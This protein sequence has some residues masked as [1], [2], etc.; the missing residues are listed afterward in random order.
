MKSKR[1]PDRVHVV[2]TPEQD[3]ANPQAS[4]NIE[5][6]RMLAQISDKLKR[7]EAERYELLNELREY[8]KSLR[9]LEDKSENSEKAYLA[10]ENTVK[11]KGNIDTESLQRQARFEKS[12]KETEDKIVKAIAGQ[13]LIDKRIS[14]AESKQV[15]IDQR[16]D[17]SVAEQARLDRQL[18]LTAQDKARL[19]RKVERL[20]D[21]VTETQDTLRSKAM[22][23]L[24]DQS[25]AAGT[26]SAPAWGENSPQP[27][28]V[29]D[30]QEQSLWARATSVQTLSISALIIAA[31]LGGYA[32][33]QIQKPDFPEITINDNGDLASLGNPPANNLSDVNALEAQKIE[34]RLNI[35][36]ENTVNATEASAGTET[37]P[38]D[39]L[40]YSDDQLIE[41][42]NQDPEG[43]AAQLNDIEPSAANAQTD[44]AQEGPLSNPQI[45]EPMAN[46]DAVAFKQDPSI[47]KA[48]AESK[49][50]GTLESRMQP[51]GNLPPSVRRI[52][53][54]AFKGN[55]EA[56]H[57][58]AAIYTA[59]QGG[60][61]QNFEKAAFWFREASDN[62]IANARY[63]LGVLNHQGLGTER[64]LD[65]A[66]YWYRE[67]AKLGHAE[68][69]YNLGIAHI[70]GIGTDY[71]PKL[72]A[73]FF[74]RA[75]NNG[76][77]EAAYNLGLIYE[78]GLLGTAKPDEAI[79]WYKIAADQGSSDAQSALEQ[80][81]QSLQIG[82]SDIDNLVERM[83]Q[84]NQS[85][86]GRRAGPNGEA[87]STSSV[88]SNQAMI[89]QIQEYLMLTG[90]YTGPADGIN[91]PKTEEAIKAYQAANNLAVTGKPSG[92]LLNSMIGSAQ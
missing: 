77:M 50:S 48:I 71:D 55:A 87:A 72:A 26:L 36:E 52:E 20:E 18:E 65:K 6:V 84:I 81:A 66:L 83:Q 82:M 25:A 12:L 9:E 39:V 89:A 7:S 91:G 47:A 31:L 16:L 38:E 62:N 61:S 70:E 64:N 14:D 59:G 33:N 28:R 30:R 88:N 43:L 92:E 40:D 67:A 2:R 37:L 42:L 10:L 23:L 53:E 69:Q 34:N 63:N 41:A 86:K 24:T 46:F 27:K 51:D 21:V 78:N 74:E 8:R 60:V 45:T 57:D 29:E 3:T 79:L 1:V 49:P 90:E 15:A 32:I 68:A 5:I 22:V 56:Q 58:L 19:L 4:Q 54:Q 11:T 35:N 13:A 17:A 76:I 80:L 85:V 44:T 75:A 73:A